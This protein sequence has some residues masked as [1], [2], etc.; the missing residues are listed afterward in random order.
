[1]VKPVA[2]RK[3]PRDIR[4]SILIRPVRGHQIVVTGLIDKP[5]IVLGCF[6]RTLGLSNPPVASQTAFVASSACLR[7][8]RSFIR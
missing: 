1:M 7:D 5:N 4:D 3:A 2:C 6:E 8:Q